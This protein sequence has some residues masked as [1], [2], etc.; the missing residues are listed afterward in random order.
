VRLVGSQKAPYPSVFQVFNVGFF[1]PLAFGLLGGGSLK[2]L[3]YRL[4]DTGYVIHWPE[5]NDYEAEG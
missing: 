5:V 2:Y 1:V 3:R 4:H